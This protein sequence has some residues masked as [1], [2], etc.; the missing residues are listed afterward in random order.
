MSLSVGLFIIAVLTATTTQTNG[1]S[2]TPPPPGLVGWWKGEGNANDSA[3]TNHGLLSASGATYATGEIGRGFRFDGTN[4]YMQVPDAAALKPTN[5]TV[6]AWVWLD[7]NANT[8]PANESIIFKRNSWTLLFEGYSLLKV[9]I[10]NGNGTYTSRFQFVVTRNGNQV[11]INST[12]IVQRGVWYHVAATYDGNSSILFV[13]GVAEVSA[14]PGF[15]LDYGDRPVF[16]GTTGEPASYTSMFAGIIDE[17]SIYSRALATNEIAAIYSAGSGGKC[18]PA[19]CAN[20]TNFNSLSGLT[21]TGSAGVTNGILRLTPAVD[22]QGGNA[23]LTGKVGCADGFD[24]SFHFQITQLG[25]IYGNEPGGDGIS[26]SVQN[27]AQTNA[28]WGINDTNNHVAVFFNTFWNWPG[29]TCPD[30]SD[31]SVG[32][33]INGSYVAQTDLNP[34]G[35]NMSDGNVH[36]GHIAF[37]GST[38]TVWVDNRMVLTNV[39]VPGLQPGVDNGGNAWVGFTAATGAAYENHDVLDWSFCA[40]AQSGTNSQTGVPGISSFTPLAGANGAIVSILGMNFSAS[41]SSN[42]VYFGAVRANVLAASASSLIVAVPAGATFSPITVTVAGL[43]AYS[44]QSFEPTFVGN[45][46]NLTTSSLG[47]SFNLGAGDRPGLAAISD[48]DG[49]GKPDVI[50]AS[51]SGIAIYQN[52]GT[53]GMLSA[54]TFAPPIT[55]SLASNGVPGGFAAADL[56]GDGKRDLVLSDYANNQIVVFQ[57]VSS[58][59][60]LNTGSFAA[61][62]YFA[63]GAVPRGVVVRDLDGDGHPDIACANYSS[64]TV[65]I[66]RHAGTFGSI[67]TNSFVAHVDLPLAGTSEFLAAGDLDGDGKPDLAVADGTGLISL[68]RNHSTPGSIGTNSFDA[69]VDMPAQSGSLNVVIGDLDGDGKPELITSAYLPQTMSVYRNLAA[70]GSLT[71][72]SFATPVDYALAG[73]GHTI[74]LADLN[75]DGKPDI[76][77]VTELSSALSLFQNIGTGSFTS[78]S[79]AARVDFPTGWN[80]WGVAVGDLDGDGRPDIVFCN[81]YDANIQIYPNAVPFGTPAVAPVISSQPTNLSVTA[82]DTAAFS[83]TASGSPPLSYSWHFNGTNI[84]GATQAS[85]MLSN[86]S[87]AQA[88][89]YSVL[90]ANIAGAVLSSNAVLSVYMPPTPP[91]ILAQTP[92]QVVQLGSAA[93][94]SVLAGGS[95]PLIYSWSR[96]DATIPGATNASYTLLNAQLS[97]SGSRFSCLVSNAYGAV[98]STNASL[99]VINTI[100]NDLCSGAVVITNASHTNV[101]STLKASSFGDPAPACVSGFGHG[102]WYRF[103]APIAGRLI[104][105]T[106]GSDYDT[107]L[108]LYTGSC[109][110]LSELA[111]NDDSGG[112]TSRVTIPTTAGVTYFV[113]A[114][115]YGSDA[116]NLVLHLNH[117]TPPAFEVQPASISVV[118]SSNGTFSSVLSGTLPISFQWYFSNAPLA[119]GGR[120]SG[121]TSAT[122][123]IAGVQTNDGGSYFL[124]ASNMVGVTTSSVAVLTPVILPPVFLLPPVSQ[125]I[126]VGSNVTFTAVVD[127]TPPYGYQWYFGGNALVDDGVHIMGAATASLSI[128]NL[129]DADAGTYSLTVT[130]VSGSTNAEAALIVM[131][132]PVI[133]AQPAG[134]SVPPGL[135]TVFTALA[136]GVP[137]PGY[138]WQLN[139]ASI[140]GATSSAYTNAAISTNDL[141]FYQVI[142]SNLVGVTTSA[143]A[144]L[145]FGPVAAWGRN[146]SGECLPPPGLA[147]VIAVAGSLGASFAV[148]ADGTVM[149]WGSSSGTNVPPSA[150][151]VIALATSAT[152]GNYALRADGTVVGWN[153]YAAPVLSNI[154]SVAAGNGF[155]LALRAEGTV[156]GWGAPAVPVPAGLSHV[157]AI[158]CGSA[159]ALALRND[160]TVAAWGLSPATNIPAGLTGVTAI[161]A[162]YTHSLALKSNGTVAAWGSGSGTNLPSG[163]TNITA[164]ATGNLPASQTLNLALRSNGTVVAWGDSPYGETSPPAALSNLLSVAVAAAPYHGLALVNNGSPQILQPPAGRTAY[165]GRDVTLQAAAVGAAPLSYQWLL[166]GATVPG[167]TS[168]ALFLPNFQPPNAGSYQLLVSNSIGATLSLPAP[169]TVISNNALTFLTQSAG[170]MTNYQGSTI[171]LDGFAVLGNGPLSYQWFFSPTNAGYLAVPGATNDSLVLDPALARQSGYY[172]ATISNPFGSISTTPAYLKVLFARSW[173]YLALSNPPVNLTNAVA[174]AT[175]NSGNTSSSYFA[176]GADGLLKSWANYIPQY[177]ET[178]FLALSN[179]IVTAIAAGYQHA[180]ALKSDGTVYA[181]G[182]YGRTFPPAYGAISPPANL[183]GVVGIACGDYHDLALRYDGTV[184]GWGVNTYLQAT[185]NAAATNVVAVAAGSQHS[186]ALRSDG[187]VV[188]WGYNTSGQV[189]IPVN[190]TNVIGLAAGAAFSAALRADGTVVQWGAGLSNYPV[191]SG[192]SNVVAISGSSTHCTALRNDG[193]V[194]SWGYEASIPASG[195][196]PANLANVIAIT[197]G[198]DHDFALF[199]TRAPAF[200]VQPWNR[201]AAQNVA[202]RISLTGKCAG[203]QPVTY[204]WRLNGTNLPGATSDTLTLTNQP[205]PSQ[206]VRF[207]PGGDYQLVASNAYGVAISKPAKVIV[208]Y[209][210]GDALN[211]TNLAWTT[212]GGAQW[213]GQTNISRDAVAS[214]RSGGIGALQET[215]LQATLVTNYSGRATFWWKVSSEEFF[216]TLEFRVNGTVQAVTF[217]EVDW[218]FVSIPMAAGTNLL[219]WRYSKDYTFD[220]GLDAAFVDQFAFVPDPPVIT[221]QPVSQVVNMG[222]NVT[223]RVTATGYPPFTFRWF[224]NGTNT[225]G[226]SSVL[227]LS[228]VGRAQNATYSAVVSNIGG[229]TFSSPAL[230]KVLVPQLLGSPQ[231]LPDGSFLLSSTDANGGLLSPSDLANL[232]ARASTNFVDWVNLPDAL[233]L[234]NG[235]LQLHDGSSSNFIRRYY[236]IVEH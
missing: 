62:V 32:I 1:A 205:G 49:D 80:P 135:P 37:D 130:N 191:P 157:T 226:S 125:S 144:Q 173:G 104:V 16:I 72:S 146:N 234:T 45:G 113:L 13:N 231:R 101:Q 184:V 206:P 158:A 41:A 83:V 132:P 85:L 98:A 155:A 117:L 90:V 180:L 161:A 50:V 23:W 151:N 167:A 19:T 202:A 109:N 76:T 114:G 91:A 25:N 92:S 160:G 48:L 171:T 46:S 227:T 55:I 179:S 168:P 193:T 71:I 30:V 12:S 143:V 116:G 145:T 198:S 162:G 176:L 34:T 18:L 166:N 64:G 225:V 139:G 163:L 208:I 134:R 194:V 201:T 230:L 20:Y 133:T 126:P 204:Q 73:R 218:Q 47:P 210:L 183:S 229:G 196:V 131:V 140:P 52:V 78:A 127:G 154:V 40:A 53:N 68:F 138:Q 89:S 112:V 84:P 3:G 224:A 119:D 228:N 153:G 66:L 164:I 118:V 124:I 220:T 149:A 165:S 27:T 150:S 199:G 120:I 181:A 172:Q 2:C 42:I 105:D 17:P 61:P 43:T 170:S 106:A 156:V 59:G 207:I 214:A 63:V 128:S 147:D 75:G 213:Y 77:E 115:G 99:K 152:T 188:G 192:L 36:S 103:T 81:D 22:A 54:L 209:P 178:N 7:P 177:G 31:N 189:T 65:S 14:T 93:T 159:H 69:R 221:L 212:S 129:S 38:M 8:G 142:A 33:L 110:A 67:T 185:N 26:F 21:L 97:D 148:R 107:G 10:D 235:L 9:S 100:Y 211:A 39:P 15:P 219:Q 74:A 121:A 44:G 232:E 79:L 169:V 86:V 29:C 123:N 141:G 87:P 182:Y 6:E 215:V 56:D 122:L 11:A 190:A 35:I 95:D 102:V 174:I 186:L 28:G 216:D 222:A 70:P 175:G 51:S 195:S 136:S 82:G 223:F 58:S 24:T 137:A 57:N 4:G 108:A 96:N 200:T 217:G 203:A 197:S 60:I 88:G 236:R 187:S 111:C 94:F 5:V 233:S